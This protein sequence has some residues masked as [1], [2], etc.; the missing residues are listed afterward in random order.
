MKFRFYYAG[1]RVRD[2]KKS[3]DFYTKA[4]GM[5]VVDNGTMPHGGEYVQL[6][7]KGVEADPRAELVSAGQQV[8][9]GIHRGRGDG[10]SGVRREG[11]RQGAQRARLEGTTSAVSP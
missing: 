8:L 1:I 2:S 9:L 6:R 3:R 10:P 4:S 11:R 5:A 7:G